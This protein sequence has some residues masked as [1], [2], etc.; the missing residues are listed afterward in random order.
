M[1]VLNDELQKSRKNDMKEVQKSIQRLYQKFSCLCSLISDLLNILHPKIT[2]KSTETTINSENVHLTPL[3]LIAVT[4]A[5]AERISGNPVFKRIL[6]T[7]NPSQIRC[8]KCNKNGHIARYCHS[9][10]TSYLGSNK[11]RYNYKYQKGP[12]GNFDN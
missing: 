10:K 11:F 2:S 5:L 6:M 12:L 4:N 9:K 3:Q 1:V 8:Y 7:K